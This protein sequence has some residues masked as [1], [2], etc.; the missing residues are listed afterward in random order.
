MFNVWLDSEL[1]SI[2]ID[3][4]G[5]FC[6]IGVN[7]TYISYSVTTFDDCDA[8]TWSILWIDELLKFLGY[9]RDG[10]L[11]VYWN[12]PGKGIGEGLVLVKSDA[13]IV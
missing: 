3:H 5:F 2:E 4:G 1:F 6:G 7:L 8:D 13:E 11:H 9:E 12:L 10:K